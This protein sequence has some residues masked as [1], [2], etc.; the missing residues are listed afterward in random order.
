M[1][2]AVEYF[3]DDGDRLEDVLLSCIANYY[4]KYCELMGGDTSCI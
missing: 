2:Q 4:Y 3:S 1:Y